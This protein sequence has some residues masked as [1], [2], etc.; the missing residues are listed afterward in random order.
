MDSKQV[1]DRAQFRRYAEAALSSLG[2]VGNSTEAAKLSFD[3]AVAMMLDELRCWEIYQLH[4]L[5]RITSDERE[6]HAKENF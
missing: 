5:K 2:D 3:R 4:A 1:A 6:R